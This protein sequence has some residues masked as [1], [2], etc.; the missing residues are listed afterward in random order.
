MRIHTVKNP[1]GDYISGAKAY[2]DRKILQKSLQIKEEQYISV[3]EKQ[4]VR[5]MVKQEIERQWFGIFD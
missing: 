1:Y 2:A 4:E 5:E 3:K